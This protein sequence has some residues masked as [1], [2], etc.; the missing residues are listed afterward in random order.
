M[1]NRKTELQWK[2][3]SQSS[4]ESDDLRSTKVEATVNTGERGERN[5]ISSEATHQPMNARFGF[6]P[7]R[8]CPPQPAVMRTEKSAWRSLF[9]PGLAHS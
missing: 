5:G 4:Q 6:L 7:V 3:K 9:P 8:H 1:K 2:V